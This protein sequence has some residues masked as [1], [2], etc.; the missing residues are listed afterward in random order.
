M[1]SWKNIYY[2]QVQ[3]SEVWVLCIRFSH[4]AAVKVWLGPWSHLNAQ[5]GKVALPRSLWLFTRFCSLKVVD[6]RASVLQMPASVLWHHEH[7][8]GGGV[9]CF[10]SKC[11]SQEEVQNASKIKVTIFCDLM[12]SVKFFALCYMLETNHLPQFTCKGRAVKTGRWGG[13][14][15]WKPPGV[16]SHL[17]TTSDYSAATQKEVNR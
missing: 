13:G 17:H 4:T 15:L 12:I 5:T 11:T 1:A 16:S 8:P 2:L 3:D 7:V 10:L 14:H 9:F 6:L